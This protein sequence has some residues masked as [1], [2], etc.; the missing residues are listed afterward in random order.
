MQCLM[1]VLGVLIVVALVVGAIYIAKTYTYY[2]T[3]V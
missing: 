2:D 3:E 1:I